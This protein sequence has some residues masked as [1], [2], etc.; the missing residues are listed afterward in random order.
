MIKHQLLT[1]YKQVTWL[2]S[3]RSEAQALGWCCMCSTLLQILLNSVSPEGYQLLFS[4]PFA[5]FRYTVWHCMYW[6]TLQFYLCMYVSLVCWYV[7]PL[8]S[9]ITTLYYV[10]IIFH[11][12][13]WYHA[14]SLCYASI[15]TSKFVHHPHPLGYVCA[16]FMFFHGLHCWA[17]PWRKIAY[18]IT[19]S[20][21]LSDAQRT[22]ACASENVWSSQC[23]SNLI[24][25]CQLLFFFLHLLLH[26]L[27]QLL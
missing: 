14:L 7:A 20:P 11:R 16:K 13:V 22:E 1:N 4:I 19:H 3:P 5:Y 15:Q 26:V 8:L 25:N 23:A 21:S 12:R 2:P 24:F 10:A 9:V 6:P 27:P 18:S 17:S